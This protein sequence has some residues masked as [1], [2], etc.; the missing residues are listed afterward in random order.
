MG[1]TLTLLA[2]LR[3]L[4]LLALLLL[5]GTLV[6]LVAIALPAGPISG[7]PLAAARQRLLALTHWAAAA[8]LLSGCAWLVM[9]ASVIGSADSLPQAV[10]VLWVVI[11]KTQFGHAVVLRLA[12]LG[13]ALPL[14]RRPRWYQAIALGLVVLSVTLQG[15]VGHAGAI[16]GTEGHALIASEAL[17]L[18]AA[19]A[20]LGAL[21]PLVLLIAALPPRDAAMMCRRFSPIGLAAV[22]V[23]M[24]TALAQA[25]A[26]IGD[27]PALV[28]TTYGRIAL[29]KLGLFL[30]LL[31]LALANRFVL[32]TKLERD[33][34]GGARRAM[35]RSVIAET[36]LGIGVI[37]AA[38]FLASSIPALHEQPSWPFAWR[39]S[40]AAMADPD[41]RREVVNAFVAIGAALTIAT[42]GLVW[43]RLR[44]PALA[45][46]AVALWFALPQLDLLLV[47][48][49]PTSY[50]VSPTG[51]AAESI[52]RG[53]ALFPAHCAA[54][55]GA[56]G[57]G[58]GPRAAQLPVRPADLTAPHLWDHADGDLFWW[59]TSGI[60]APE[61]GLA[62]QG[63]GTAISAD[64]RWALI[65]YIR[66]H[67]AGAIMAAAG[68]WPVPVHVPAFPIDC[69]GVAADD[70]TGLT[71]AVLRVMSDA[72]PGRRAAVPIPPQEG[73]RTIVLRVSPDAA[74]RPAAGECA[75]ATPAAWPAFAVLAGLDPDALDG[76]EFLVDPQGWLRTLWRPGPPGNARSP[77]QLITEIRQIIT[78]P[79]TAQETRAHAHHH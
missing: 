20:W 16:G 64:D 25:T 79:I 32:A 76:T 69:D 43:R 28:G 7:S 26:L 36:G 61:G 1:A 77:D 49:H 39:P 59:L 22:L 63:F 41:L 52:A 18:I 24:G 71:G 56:T 35:L 57:H 27:G 42:L 6:T 78:H 44:W 45:I 12:L 19:G 51:F 62:M 4:H 40:L 65:D 31:V 47:E 50:Y 8:A 75:A 2:A 55:H 60:E 70:S 68:A 17:H 67:N 46:A 3:G 10:S 21:P 5:L 58:D 34:A 23:L 30:V 38:S 11:R 73:V 33:D 29:L 14:L 9:Q 72:G 13:L 53:A 15:R 37:L 54:C 74:A 66:A 48:A